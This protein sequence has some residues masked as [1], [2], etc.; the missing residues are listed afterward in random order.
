VFVVALVVGL[1]LVV[2]KERVLGRGKKAGDPKK[3]EPKKVD[4]KKVEDSE[5]EQS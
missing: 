1:V 3:V 2:V 4:E 5:S